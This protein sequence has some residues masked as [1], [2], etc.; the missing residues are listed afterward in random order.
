MSGLSN[1]TV[2]ALAK[3][4]T[5]GTFVTPSSSTDLIVVADLRPQI[6]G[7]TS[8][9]QEYTGSIHRPGPKVGGATFEVS[10]RALIRG[11]GG[12][13]PPAADAFILGRLLQA[14]GFTETRVTSAIPAAPEAV[15][16]GGSTTT[17]TL[18]STATGTADLYNGHAIQLSANLGSS[19]HN[20]TPIADYSAAKLAT[21]AETAA[22]ALTSG[23]YQILKQLVYR[24]ASATPPTL[25]VSCWVGGRRYDGA[26]CSMSSFKINL[27][28]FSR[29]S[30]DYPSIEFTLTGNLQASA[31]EAAPTPTISLSPAPFKDGKL[32]I[33]KKDLGGSSLEIDFGAEIAYAPNP[34]LATGSEAAQLTQTT[35][36]VNLTLNQVL[37]ATFDLIAAADAQAYHTILAQYGLA[38]GNFM[39]LVVPEARFNY[40]SPDNGGALV[41]D[42]GQ[43]FID[44]STDSVM[45]SFPYYS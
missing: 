25:S 42:T 16:G 15:G 35:R 26:G 32:A 40:F 29:E 9:V 39:S 41:N 6:Q 8:D 1:N 21:L 31:D 14:V 38:S 11:P 28:T 7:L 13:G 27:P 4:T 36:S 2:L 33:S 18:G 17:V 5:P 30:T 34:N 12:S 19:P 37:A 10:G 24:L 43:L 23:N 3:E 20:I 22:G 44:G 45:L